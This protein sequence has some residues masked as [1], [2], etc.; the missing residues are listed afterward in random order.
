M[1]TQTAKTIFITGASSGLGKATARLFAA[2]GWRVLA[3]MRRPEAETELARLA[4]VEL[5]ALD[6]TDPAQ[7]ESSVTQA[8]ALGPVNVVFNNAGY[9]ISGPLEGLTDKQIE[10]SVQTNLMGPIRV[11]KAFIPHFRQN[12]GGLFINTTS[13]GGLITF[14]FN[15]MYHATKWGLEGWSESMAFELG[16]LGIGMKIVEPGGIKTDFF[17]RS[18][19]VGNHPAYGDLA[20]RFM[21]VITDETQMQHYSTPEDIAEVVYAAATDGTDQLR[22]L[23]GDD[24]KAAYA[25]R[26]QLGDEQFRRATAQQFLSTE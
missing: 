17:S 18:M 21:G 12:G 5:L 11:T 25:A 7:I 8:V 6:V 16:Q 14:P 2:R 23:A 26:L 20:D 19:D 4:G 15:A 24:A 13:V 9:G 10:R 22:Y 1:T 3:T